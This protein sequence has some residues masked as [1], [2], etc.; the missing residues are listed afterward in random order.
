MKRI[1]LDDIKRVITAVGWGAF[2][3]SYVNDIAEKIAEDV[4]KDVEESSAFMDDGFWNDDDVRLAI[5]RVVL[6]RLGDVDTVKKYIRKL[7]CWYAEKEK[8]E[9][10]VERLCTRLD[11]V[12]HTFMVRD[13][14]TVRESKELIEDARKLL[15]EYK[16]ETE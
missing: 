9:D 16:D 5:G 13:G 11:I 7:G 14:H 12:S 8:L 2:S 1:K 10:M 3:S 15:E 4:R 6:D